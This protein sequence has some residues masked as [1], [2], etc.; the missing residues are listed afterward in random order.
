MSCITDLG[1]SQV[2]SKNQNTFLGQTGASSY[3][4]ASG[5]TVQVAA[6]NPLLELAQGIMG[7][8]ATAQGRGDMAFGGGGGI[9]TIQSYS[10]PLG[11]IHQQVAW[12][13]GFKTPSV[14]AGTG[15]TP[16]ATI[17]TDTVAKVPVNINDGQTGVKKTGTGTT[18]T[19]TTGTGATHPGPG[20]AW[21]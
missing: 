15:T 2:N 19:G 3:K 16:A 9:P 14:Q 1:A 21:A 7:N 5:N 17:P 12:K 11:N 20:T 6:K 10:D 8:A 13:G 18:G 4:D